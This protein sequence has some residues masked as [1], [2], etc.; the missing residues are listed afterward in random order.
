M[1][2]LTVRSIFFLSTGLCL[3]IVGCGPPL[4][5]EVAGRITIKAEAPKIKGLH[6][7]FIGRDGQIV[8]A[9]IDEEGNYRA[10]GVPAGE[11]HVSFIFTPPGGSSVNKK[12]RFP[13]KGEAQGKVEPSAD[14][15]NPIPKELRDGSTSNITV[16]VMSGRCQPFDYDIK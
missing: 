2:L 9:P 5:G 6:I 16:E 12:N 13:G 11:A 3:G 14:V 7:S 15:E 4:P 8:G 1:N 10:T